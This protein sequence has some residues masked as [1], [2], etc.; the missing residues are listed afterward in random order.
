MLHFDLALWQEEYEAI[1]LRDNVAKLSLNEDM[2]VALENTD[3]RRITEVSPHD[4]VWG[5][6]LNVSSVRAVFPTSWCGPNLPGEALERTR[7]MQRRNTSSDNQRETLDPRDDDNDDTVF[8]A[9]LI[10]YLCL[11]KALLI[12]PT[13]AAQLSAFNDSVPDY[14]APEVLL[15]FAPCVITPLIPEQGPDLVSGILTMDDPTFTTLLS[16]SSEAFPISRYTSTP[17]L[18][19]DYLN[20]LSTKTRLAKWL[21][22]ASPTHPMFVLP[23]PNDA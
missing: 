4:T 23:H 6:G 5:I 7:E 17:S 2:P 3:A 20:R 12:I 13:H 18:I 22:R 1:V 16:L 9:V 8:E 21:Q 11:D 10:T 14:H 19:Q 15:A